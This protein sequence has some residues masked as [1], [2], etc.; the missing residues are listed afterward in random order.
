M[1]CYVNF[2]FSNEDVPE[3]VRNEMIK[4]YNIMRDI[5]CKAVNPMFEEWNA[6]YTDEVHGI[7]DMVYNSFISDKENEVFSIINKLMFVSP[8]K[9][10]AD[11]YADIRGK[12][13]WK[14]KEVLI[15]A[16]LIPKN[17]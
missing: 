3:N 14:G 16:V 6:L 9:L 5:A 13:K 4:C 7:D 12:F 8:V 17:D 10:W 2:I 11:E 15:T 1:L